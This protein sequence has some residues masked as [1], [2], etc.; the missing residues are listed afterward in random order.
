VNGD[1][2]ARV[3]HELGLLS[4]KTKLTESPE[5]VI[6]YN[7]TCGGSDGLTTDVLVPVPNGYAGSMIDYAYLPEGSPLRG[8]VKGQPEEVWIQAD[9]RRWF[10]V[11]YHPH[12]NGGGP[13]WDSSKHGFHTYVDEILTWLAKR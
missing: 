3:E 2:K 8:K 13:P 9:G 11:S 1:V 4:Y 5:C 7:L 10:R 6:Y 12:A